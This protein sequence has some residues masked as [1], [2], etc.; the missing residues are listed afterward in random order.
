MKRTINTIIAAAVLAF[1]LTG[2]IREDAVVFRGVSDVDFSLKGSP[3][4][5]AVLEAENKSNR[6]ISLRDAAFS[7]TTPEGSTIGKVMLED[8]L[9]IPKRSVTSLY[10]SLKV[11]IDNPFKVLALLGDLENDSPTLFV[12]GSVTVKAGC[13]KKKIRV[14]EMPLRDFIT[15]IQ[16]MVAA[17]SSEP[18][19]VP[20]LPL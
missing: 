17:S 3:R 8:E 5:S 20:N 1:M 15:R 19:A 4:I 18:Q 14:K 13:I 11:S 16:G 7:V 6:N 2:C 12:N 9:F 10:V